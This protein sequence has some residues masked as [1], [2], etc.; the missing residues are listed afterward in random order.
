[1]EVTFDIETGP[2]PEDQLKALCPA[3]DP[4]SVKVGN[5]KDPEKIKEKVEKAEK[6]HFTKF[7]NKSA[8]D[9]QTGMVLVLAYCF[10]DDEPECDVF[11]DHEE[12]EVSLLKRFNFLLDQSLGAKDLLIGF[13]IKNFDLP[14]LVR[15]M[16]INGLKP[17][18]VLFSHF[19]GRFSWNENVTDAYEEW[20][21][22]QRPFDKEASAV[23]NGLDTVSKSLLGLGKSGDL[24]KM[25]SD[26][27]LEDRKT[28]LEYARTDVKR[29]REVWNTICPAVP[30]I[31]QPAAPPQ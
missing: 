20:M 31:P 7:L 2:L 19:R 5:T 3:F 4:D 18:P 28:A 8:L 25:F 26:H 10:D 13:G 15:R 14:F 22:G 29:T 1:M 9:P 23:S 30:N 12:G 21:L 6:E 11:D 27:F 16:W 17:A 24:G